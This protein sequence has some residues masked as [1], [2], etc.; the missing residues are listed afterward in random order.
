MP[1]WRQTEAL[2]EA[3]LTRRLESFE[4]GQWTLRVAGKPARGVDV[5]HFEYDTIDGSGGR[6]KASS[7]LMIPAAANGASSR[8]IPIVVALHGTMPDKPYNLADLSGANPASV[9][10]IALAAVYAASGYIVVAPNYTGLDTSDARCQS[11]LNAE[12]Q[13][14][15][16]LD[17][18]A[19]ARS[20]LPS[21]SAVASDRL[22]VTGYSQGGWLAMAL[23]REMEA[24]GM[25]LTASAPASGPYAL[26]ALVD[27][28]F[29][30][31]PVCGSTVYFPLAIRSYQDAYGDVY[32]RPENVY[33]ANYA[34]D[35]PDMLPTAI[36]HVVLM[37]EGRLPKT[38]L[39]SEKLDF[40]DAAGTSFVRTALREG[41]PSRDPE[42][43]AA[44]YRA[45]FGP[46]H[47]LNDGFRRSYLA[48][49]ES[50]P[51]GAHPAFT[52][53]LPPEKSGNGLR[54]AL[55][56]NDLRNF[57]P[58]APM[59]LCGGQGDGAMPFRLGA[60]LMMQY[61][62][63][64]ARAPK[65]GVVSVLDFEAPNYEGAPFEAL[66]RIFRTEKDEYLAS[67]PWPS[68]TDAYHQFLLPRFCYL[69]ARDFFDTMR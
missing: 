57:T 62:R 35:V 44:I 17:A 51:D 36:S 25:A 69:A 15:D 24:R 45:G 49:M 8:P 48:D 30:G 61:W 64:P 68:W 1:A 52:N 39:F 66:R 56:R 41:S 21:L 46:D 59:M 16:V 2:S 4:E 19:A 32:V 58:I 38:A 60:E 12:Q 55:I 63:S 50:N 14:Q 43:F 40:E 10:A 3:E 33:S 54:R 34:R 23:H 42:R 28:V 29:L 7:A 22:F 5:Y 6:A 53:G 67:Q 65:P 20:L 13:T 47:L 31:R 27:D 37:Q 9:R 11:Y 26:C 18:L